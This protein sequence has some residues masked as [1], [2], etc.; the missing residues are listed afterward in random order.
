MAQ[1]VEYMP[2]CH[3]VRLIFANISQDSWAEIYTLDEGEKTA[4]FIIRISKE[5]EDALI[6]DTLV[7]EYAHAC[8]WYWEEDQHGPAFGI[9]LAR[10]WS[11]LKD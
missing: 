11:F 4:R 6:A 1:L 7:H 5:I 8:S 3:P 2:V 10:L 9:A